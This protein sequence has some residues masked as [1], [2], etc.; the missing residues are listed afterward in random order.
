MFILLPV[1]GFAHSAFTFAHESLVSKS[2]VSQSDVPPGA[3]ITFL[4]KG[5][6]YV[7]IEEHIAEVGEEKRREER[8][9]SEERERRETKCVTL[10]RVV[11]LILIVTPIPILILMFPFYSIALR[12]GQ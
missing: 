12:M 11:V 9:R 7:G 10:Q 2:T 6:E 5:L 8:E 3:L 1:V 4:Q